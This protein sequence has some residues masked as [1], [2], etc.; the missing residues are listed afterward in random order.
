MAAVAAMAIITYLTRISGVFIMA[1]AGQGLWLE[2]FCNALSGSVIVA[3]LVPAIVSGDWIFRVAV[4]MSGA[5][6]A[7]T[8]NSL[9][10]MVTGAAVASVLR[11]W[12]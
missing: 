6:M 1:R 10:A 5:V 3:L 8:G 2:G 11:L 7:A 9:L 12:C 4:A